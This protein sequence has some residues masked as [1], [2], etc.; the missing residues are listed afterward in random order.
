MSREDEIRFAHNL[1]AA[2]AEYRERTTYKDLYL[3]M[4][5]EFGWPRWRPGHAWVKRL[6]L[7]EVGT[8]C[9]ELGEPCLPA[10]VRHKDGNI[11][12]GYQTAHLNCYGE[13]LLDH[14]YGCECGN[15]D[16][17]LQKVARAVTQTCWGYFAPKVTPV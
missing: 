14:D 3:A 2:H 4:A 1:L 8:L 7:A 11:G 10:L 17:V 15:C 5:P 9:G 6:P 16:Y 12:V 13:R